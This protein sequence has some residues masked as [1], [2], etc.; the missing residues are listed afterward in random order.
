[1]TRFRRLPSNQVVYSW[2]P[3]PTLDLTDVSPDVVYSIE[4][5]N[6]TCGANDLLSS[7]Y[8]LNISLYQSVLLDPGHVYKVVIVPRSNVQGSRNGPTFTEYG[9]ILLINS[10]LSFMYNVSLIERFWR[11]NVS[12]VALME[13]SLGVMIEFGLQSSMVR[14]VLI[15]ASSLGQIIIYFLSCKG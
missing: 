15:S 8:N 4:V 10:T 2:T 6:V 9:K 1:M 7:Q 14:V 5:Y 12:S 3:P 13:N 11:M